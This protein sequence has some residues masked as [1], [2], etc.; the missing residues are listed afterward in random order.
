MKFDS[1][2]PLIG[3]PV[4]RATWTGIPSIWWARNTSPASGLAR[5]ACRY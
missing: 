5:A 1:H 3:I 4:S 2:S